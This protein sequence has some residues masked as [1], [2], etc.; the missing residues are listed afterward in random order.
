MCIFPHDRGFNYHKPAVLVV[1]CLLTALINAHIKELK[2]HANLANTKIIAARFLEIF[3]SRKLIGLFKAISIFLTSMEEV[4]LLGLP[5]STKSS[6]GGLE[7]LA[8]THFLSVS[9]KTF[10]EDLDESYMWT[11][12]WQDCSKHRQ[13]KLCGSSLDFEF[14]RE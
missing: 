11:S 14:I 2:D 4:S 3:H 6:F 9:T 12:S 13:P 1:V 10:A 7:V 5:G 8:V